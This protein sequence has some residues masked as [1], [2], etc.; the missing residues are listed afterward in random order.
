MWLTILLISIIFM[1]LIALGLVSYARWNFGSLEK[2]G[3]PVVQRDHFLLASALLPYQK[4]GGIVDTEHMKKY[5]SVFGVGDPLP[6]GFFFWL[7]R[8]ENNK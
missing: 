8:K 5:G 1:I 3:I 4:P 7:T 6:A 2:L